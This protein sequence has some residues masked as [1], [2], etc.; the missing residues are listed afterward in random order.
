MRESDKI[1]NR[2]V[3]VVKNV[4]DPLLEQLSEVRDL[5]WKLGR[6]GTHSTFSE[7]LALSDLCA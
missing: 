1:I 4:L 5:I 2:R 6:V 7:S 3:Q